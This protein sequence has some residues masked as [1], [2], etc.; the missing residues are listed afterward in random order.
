MSDML[1]CVCACERKTEDF[2]QDSV[3][4]LLQQYL[5]LLLQFPTMLYCFTTLSCVRACER[6]RE[7][8]RR[9]GVEILLER[10]ADA[11]STDETETQTQKDLC[12]HSL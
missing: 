12:G 5:I 11:D 6:M 2:P 9:E 10:I 7:D 3:D 8:Y 4:N 1:V